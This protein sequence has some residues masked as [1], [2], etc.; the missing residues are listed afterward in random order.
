MGTNPGTLLANIYLF[1]HGLEFITSMAKTSI[2]ATQ[3]NN[4]TLNSQICNTLKCFLNTVRCVDDILCINNK[5]F[6]QKSQILR[7]KPVGGE[8]P[9]P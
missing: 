5:Y 1:S 4:P 6:K 8:R 2:N 7:H 3:C 9:A